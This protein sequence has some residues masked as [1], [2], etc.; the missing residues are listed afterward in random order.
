MVKICAISDIHG[1]LIDIPE[2]DI[3]CICGDILPFNM[4]KNIHY[5]IGWLAGPFQQWALAAPCKHVVMIWGNHDFIGENFYKGWLD[6]EDIHEIL[7]QND[8]GTP[9]IHILCDESIELLGV[10]F[11]GTSWCPSLKNW[12][13]YGD[14]KRLKEKFS[15]IP[16]DTNILLTHCP[17]KFGKQGM[18]LQSDSY[19][20]LSDYGCKE[21][22]EAIEKK[23]AVKSTTT[24]ILS[25]HIHSGNHCEEVH[26]GFVY[27]NVSV[28]DED[29]VVSYEPYIL[30][31]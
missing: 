21:L 15:N 7:F 24:F 26:G 22:Q 13:F 1:D 18:V 3:L 16:S 14:S 6:S 5:S 30:E 20:Y 4:E 10:K 19:N 28:K 27:R 31:I 2:C 29:Y 11:Y 8:I 23:F 9:K 12:A 25:G 17:P